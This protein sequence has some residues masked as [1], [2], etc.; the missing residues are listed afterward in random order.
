MINNKITMR[1]NFVILSS[2]FMTM[3]VQKKSQGLMTSL[4]FRIPNCHKKRDK[5]NSHGLLYQKIKNL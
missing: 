5:I 3:G 1:T 4:D 2:Y